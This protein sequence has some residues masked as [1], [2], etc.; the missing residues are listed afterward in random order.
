MVAEA[1]DATTTGPVGSPPPAS[2]SSSSVPKRKG[3]SKR[4]RPPTDATTGPGIVFGR[5]LSRGLLSSSI[6]DDTAK[7]QDDFLG[8]ILSKMSSGFG[9]GSIA[10]AMRSS[11]IMND[12]I[13]HNTFKMAKAAQEM[14]ERNR[15]SYGKE[16]WRCKGCGTEDRSV[17]EL[18]AERSFVNC[19]R[20]GAA[21]GSA[22]AVSNPFEKTVSY[23]RVEEEDERDIGSL[24]LNTRDAKE[25]RLVR[26]SSVSGSCVGR[27]SSSSS[28]ARAHASVSRSGSS[29]S[30]SHGEAALSAHQRTKRDSVVVEIHDLVRKAGRNPDTCPIFKQASNVASN[31]FVKACCHASVCKARPPNCPG[32]LCDRVPKYIAREAVCRVLQE[33]T[34]DVTLG[35]S[36]QVLS[37]EDIQNAKNSLMPLLASYTNKVSLRNVIAA[38]FK[39][40]K[41]ATVDSI[42]NE[43]VVAMFESSQQ[44]TN[45]SQTP[46]GE[47]AE[48]APSADW[49]KKLSES[50]DALRDMHLINRDC[51]RES[52]KITTSFEHREWLNKVVH[53]PPDLVSLI[54]CTRVAGA[55][56]T[57]NTRT[58]LNELARRNGLST[59]S[60][61]LLIGDVVVQ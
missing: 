23:Q 52:L 39:S 13:K 34:T 9:G 3:P 17:L 20:C 5:S 37:S 32:V 38:E 26:Q 25:R 27:A 47:D 41:D 10:D 36:S 15:G 55:T 18:N 53:L 51:H 2:S 7:P 21:D 22:S 29:H 30:S 19:S 35:K 44:T 8:D 4:K 58:M 60:L 24:V 48:E 50:F 14:D 54:I 31:T 6:Y 28:I 43:C 33:A 45:E 61:S 11:A 57:S 12:R 1:V 59:D 42:G 46:T 49:R 56:S 16:V 40:A